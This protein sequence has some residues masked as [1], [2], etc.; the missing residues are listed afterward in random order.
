MTRTRGLPP[1]AALAAGLALLAALG[2]G[3]NREEKELAVQVVK[4]AVEDCLQAM[5]KDRVKGQPA[6]VEC[7]CAGQKFHLAFHPRD[8]RLYLL[9]N[10]TAVESLSFKVG[11]LKVRLTDQG[12]SF[13]VA[14]GGG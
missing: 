9:K 14:A 13:K 4:S 1:A 12:G 11:G 5:A 3:P 8:N 10:G 2:C 7:Q 6:D